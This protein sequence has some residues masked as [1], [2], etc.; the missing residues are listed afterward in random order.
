MAI[1]PG[2]SDGGDIGNAMPIESRKI[3][4]SGAELHVAVDEYCRANPSK[5]P[6]GSLKECRP[7]AHGTELTFRSRDAERL[8]SHSTLSRTETIRVLVQF[9]IGQK[10]PMP[11]RGEKK[12]ALENGQ[13]CLHITLGGNQGLLGRTE[14]AASR[15]AA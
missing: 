1:Y 12:L 14:P 7:T 6:N 2:V 8:R 9:C 13:I 3:I 10:I 15:A 4:L 5:F 11:R